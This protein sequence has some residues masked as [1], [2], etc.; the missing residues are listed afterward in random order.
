MPLMPFILKMPHSLT[1]SALSGV[2]VVFGHAFPIYL[3]SK[4]EWQLHQP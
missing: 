1:I 2:A 4:V 3:D